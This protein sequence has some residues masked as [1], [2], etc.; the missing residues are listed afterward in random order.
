MGG[1]G[2]WERCKADAVVML[3]FKDTQVGGKGKLKTLPACKEC[4]AETLGT[5]VT[6]LEAKSL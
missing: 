4:W 6:I 1:T 5:G 2:L 3:K